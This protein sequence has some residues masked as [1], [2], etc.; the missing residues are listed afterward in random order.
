MASSLDRL[1][2]NLAPEDLRHARELAAELEVDVELLRR[3]GVYPYQWVDSPAKFEETSLPPIEAFYNDLTSEACKTKDYK[4]AIRV[5][6]AA[7]CKSFGDYHDLYLRLDVAL[8]TDVYESFRRSAHKTYALDP[9]HYYTL[10]GFAWD[11]LFKYTGVTL[12][13]LTDPDMY[14]ACEKAVR[15]GVCAVSHRHAKANNPRVAGFDPRKLKT[16]LRYDDAN[17]LYG[18]AMS[19][20][21]PARDFVWGDAAAWNSDRVSGLADDADRGAFLEVDLEYPTELHESHN[22]F[23]LCPER[24]T[25]PGEWLSS[26]A[27]S[28]IERVA[29]TLHARS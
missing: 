3:K 9:A 23:P 5:W 7:R 28:K 6:E 20:K 15:G 18:W 14:I 22:D 1:V 29:N 26:Y 13:L 11:A 25:P 19:Q 17:N 12:D 4:H 2:K 16:W 8:L 24:M 10:P 27:K 21:L